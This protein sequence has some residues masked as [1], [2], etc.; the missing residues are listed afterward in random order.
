MTLQYSYGKST[1]LAV[2]PS[3]LSLDIQT[4]IRHM[5]EEL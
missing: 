5:E 2:H 1:A 4:K 3:L